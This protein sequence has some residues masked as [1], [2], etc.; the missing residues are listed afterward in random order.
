V[1]DVA[2][3]LIA[4]RTIWTIG[5]STRPIE[6]FLDLL[7]GRNVSFRG[8]ADHMSSAEFAKGLVQLLESLNKAGMAIFLPS[9][10][11]ALP[12]FDDRRCSS[13]HAASRSC[14]SVTSITASCIR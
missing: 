10:L 8:Y 1:T 3:A 4:P 7:G 6:E 13:A 14:T 12:S 9:G 5:H 2:A 11:V